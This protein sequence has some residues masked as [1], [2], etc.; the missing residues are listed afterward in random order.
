MTVNFTTNK[1]LSMPTSGTEI[2]VWGPEINGNMGIIDNSFGGVATVASSISVTLS[3]AQ[4]QC[5]FIRLTGSLG[6]NVTVT[7][8]NIGSFYTFI[9]DTTNSSNFFVTLAT[10]GAGGRVVG[11]PPGTMTDIMTTVPHVR[12]KSLPHVGT[13]WD[14]A[15]SSVPAWVSG[16]TI[17]P[18]L[19][20]NGTAFSSTVYPQLAS[21]YGS[22]TLPDFRGRTGFN[23]NDG[24]GRVTATGGID[25]NTR[26]ASGGIQTTSLSSIHLPNVSFP[27]T[28]PGHTHAQSNNMHTGSQSWNGGSF[29]VAN[30]NLAN[31]TLNPTT[32]GI[33][34][35]SGGSNT[36]FAITPPGVVS[37]IRMVRAG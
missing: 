4:Y 8:P 23:L 5:A 12:F 16:C 9:N 14:H 36:A 13:Y 33:T 24:T 25:G 32:T 11:L 21:I 19:Y 37:G 29:T 27:V 1:G 3:S 34:V 2:G 10:T 7:L 20:C 30:R 22:T 18:W 6:S 17:A 26:F 28:D 15:G 35:N 31:L